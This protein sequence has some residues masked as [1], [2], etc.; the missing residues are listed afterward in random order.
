MSGVLGGGMLN[1]NSDANAVSWVED[2]PSAMRKLIGGFAESSDTMDW[3]ERSW[4]RA[5]PWRIQWN[6]PIF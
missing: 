5:E 6:N 3:D 4:A 1:E 2:V